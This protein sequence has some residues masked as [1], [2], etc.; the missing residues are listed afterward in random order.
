MG[1]KYIF[2]KSKKCDFCNGLLLYLTYINEKVEK[3]IMNH[4]GS[5]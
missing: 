4:L 2:I 3:W 1:Q 5:W